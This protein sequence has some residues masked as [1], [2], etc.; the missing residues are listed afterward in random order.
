VAVHPR[1]IARR[2]LSLQATQKEPELVELVALVSERRP[3][4]VVEIGT[5]H[6][7][8]FYAWCQTAQ[9]DAT[10]V[11][12]DLPEGPFGGVDRPDLPRALR[13]FAH[14]RQAVHSMRLDSREVATRTALERHLAGQAI[15]FLFIDGDHSLAGVSRDL[16]LYGALVAPGG[17]IAFHDIVEH[18]EYPVCQVDR[19]WR[20]LRDDHRH[21]EFTVPGHER[22]WGPWGGIGV[23]F[24]D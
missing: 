3:R 19:L 16:E 9:P 20:R 1:A 17:M 6:G 8:T 14:S 21:V 7:G 23:L 2:A 18:P 22:G 13:G 11:S 24:V 15:E 4:A 10:L 12:I 5:Q